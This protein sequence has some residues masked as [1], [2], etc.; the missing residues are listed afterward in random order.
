V[1]KSNPKPL[2]GEMIVCPPLN[3]PDPSDDPVEELDTG[4]TSD[5][6]SGRDAGDRTGGIPR[7][8]H[9]PGRREGVVSDPDLPWN[10]E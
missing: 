4:G 5:K 6:T 10:V 7:T 9:P 2:P 1:A 8:S 3:V